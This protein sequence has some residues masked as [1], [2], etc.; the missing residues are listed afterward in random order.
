MNGIEGN[1]QE[2]LHKG[3]RVDCAQKW[4][5]ADTKTAR[6]AELAASEDFLKKIQNTTQ[7]PVVTYA[8]LSMFMLQIKFL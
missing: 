6:H 8:Q 2:V 5:H 1:S 3:R 7:Q 4:V